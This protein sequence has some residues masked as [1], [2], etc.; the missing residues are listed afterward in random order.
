MKKVFFKNFKK[1]KICGILDEPNAKRD[2]IIIIIHGFSSTKDTGAKYVAEELSKRKINSIRIDL[3][4]RGESEP[5][6]GKTTIS[7]YVKTVNSTIGYVKKLGYKNIS[8]L[9][10]SL[11]GLIAAATA[12][13][14]RNIKKLALRAPV[15]D[16]YELL[17]KRFNKDEVTKFKKQGFY[18]YIRPDEEKLKIVYDFIEDSKK[19]SMYKKVKDIKCPVLIIHGTK[20]EIVPYKTS[21]KLVKKFTNA[22]LVLIKN[23]SHKLSIHGDL[24]QG[25]QIIGD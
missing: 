22:R 6:F 10:T 8:L 17:L 13:R 19:Y 7:N 1:Q 24:S 11:G 5:K 21:Q 18:Y 3:D 14:Y 9:G 2:K 25:L 12:L 15:A 20:D 4:N 16:Y 23:A